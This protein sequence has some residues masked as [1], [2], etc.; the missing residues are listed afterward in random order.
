M[1]KFAQLSTAFALALSF[2]VSHAVTPTDNTSA[3]QPAGPPCGLDGP[4]RPLSFDKLLE[5]F[6]LNKDGV[7]LQDEV[8]FEHGLFFDAADINKDGFLTTDE[9]QV[10]HAQKKSAGM[11]AHFAELDTN[12]D[13]HISL[14]EAENAGSP[15]LAKQFSK[16]DSDGNGLLTPAEWQTHPKKGGKH[17]HFSRLDTDGDG[18]VSRVEFVASPPLLRLDVNGDGIISEE[19]ASQPQKRGRCTR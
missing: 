2:N 12:G 15:R 16:I 7:I 4:N 17:Q 8:Q 13:G 18:L 3:Q 19:E 14:A 10:A 5:K 11:A 6:D 9:L 1:K